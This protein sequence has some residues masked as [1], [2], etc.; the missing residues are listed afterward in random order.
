MLSLSSLNNL[1]V[2]LK[3]NRLSTS[4]LINTMKKDGYKMIDIMKKQGDIEKKKTIYI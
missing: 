4:M 3:R 1:Q 2:M